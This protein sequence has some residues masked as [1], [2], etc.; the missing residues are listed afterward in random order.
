MVIFRR[1]LAFS[2]V[3][4]SFFSFVIWVRRSLAVCF[5]IRRVRFSLCIWWGG[6]GFLRAGAVRIVGLF[7]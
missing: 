6:S 4:S 7:S 1:S 2:V 5:V 3:V